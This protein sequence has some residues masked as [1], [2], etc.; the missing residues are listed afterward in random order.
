[1]TQVRIHSN[2]KSMSNHL[3]QMETNQI[4]NSN[5]KVINIVK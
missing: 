3:N 1:M 4:K 5:K 2:G